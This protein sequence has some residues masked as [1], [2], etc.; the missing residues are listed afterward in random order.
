VKLSVFLQRRDHLDV[1][2]F[3]AWWLEHVEI[4]RH[5]PGLSGYRINFVSEVRPFGVAAPQATYDGTAELWFS[6]QDALSSG[7]ES[8]DA[9]RAVHDADNACS[10]RVEFETEEH[11][12]LEGPKHI[13]GLTKLVVLLGRRP[14]LTREQFHEWWLEHVKLSRQIPGLRGYRINLIR[15]VRGAGY[16]PEDVKFDGSAELWFDTVEDVNRGFGSELGIRAVRDS[17]VHCAT[18]VRYVTQEHV[19]V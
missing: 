2:A 11:I 1:D 3:R 19:V 18:R 10:R 13:A 6:N 8:D 17:E 5:I 12:V 4:S 14:D 7:F 16:R 15:A 9:R